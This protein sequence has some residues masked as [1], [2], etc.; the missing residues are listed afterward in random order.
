MIVG[1]CYICGKKATHICK[2][3]GRPVCDEHYVPSLGM[4]VHCARGRTMKN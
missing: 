4:C 3:C 1:S 2:M